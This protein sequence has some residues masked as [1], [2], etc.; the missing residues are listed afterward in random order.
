[1]I[2]HP[3]IATALLRRR[4]LTLAAGAAYSHAVGLLDNA[5]RTFCRNGPTAPV[6]FA[7]LISGRSP[8]ASPQA[9]AFPAFVNSVWVSPRQEVA[10]AKGMLARRAGSRR[11][12]IL[13][14]IR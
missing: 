9:C 4:P 12:P 2:A 1:M 8:Q 13:A 6:R 3:L 7:R 5:Q 14:T 10:R 11:L